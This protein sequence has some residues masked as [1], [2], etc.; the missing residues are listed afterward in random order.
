MSF[1]LQYFPDLGREFS[2]GQPNA[3]VFARPAQ[4]PATLAQRLFPQLAS[5]APPP[6]TSA[7]L[8]PG[9]ELPI[10]DFV[11][12][13]PGANADPLAQKPLTLPS[14]APQPENPVNELTGVQQAG[15]PQGLIYAL[16]GVVALWAIYKFAR[17]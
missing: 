13:G 17:G 3:P 7:V 10:P 2:A 6:A 12:T 1:A 15:V 14:S 5:P 4:K 9:T 8:E 16:L 11:S